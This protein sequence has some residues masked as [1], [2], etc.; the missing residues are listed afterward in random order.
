MKIFKNKFFIVILSCAVFLTILTATL[1]AMGQTDPIKNAL[2]SLTLPLRYAA[3][4]VG[5]AIEGFESAI[6]S[7]ETHIALLYLE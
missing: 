4:A 6:F 5:E 1:S 7:T 2:N 3:D